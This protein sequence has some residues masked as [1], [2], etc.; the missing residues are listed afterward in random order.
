MI[1][2]YSRVSTQEQAASG[3][4]IDE[5]RL[6][7]E[8]F[9]RAM[10]WDDFQHF[11]DA[12]FSGGSKDRP[13]LLKLISEVQAGRVERVLVYKLDRLSR[14]QKDTL[15]LIEDVFLRNGA[16]FVS[17]TE[18]FDTATP[19][20]KAMVGIL[21]VFAQLEREQI[22][23]R[24][25]MGR[26]ARSKAGAFHGS[27]TIPIGY[28]YDGSLHVNDYEA[29]LVRAVFEKAAA[30]IPVRR[31]V[32]EMNGDGL[33]H[34]YGPW[35]AQTVRKML[36]RRTYLGEVCFKGTWYAG[37]HEPIIDT[38]LFEDVQRIRIASHEKAVQENARLGRATSFL[39][40]LVFCARCGAR[41]T[42]QTY[43][44]GKY[45]YRKYA[46]ASRS[47]RNPERITD[48]SCKNKTWERTD[49]EGIVFE[50]V[51][52]LALDPA[53]MGATPAGKA[54]NRM[55]LVQR[56]DDSIRRLVELYAV[57]S[58][59]LEMVKEKTQALAAQKEAL[60]NTQPPAIT[61]QDA[62]QKAAT[63]DDFLSSGSFDEVRTLLL[64]LI[65]RI[66]IDGDDITIRWKFT[67]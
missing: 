19:F 58:V 61:K 42:A 54:D 31:I 48:P 34:K 6:R 37:K 17:M 14:S 63:L 33:F 13:A 57:G 26:T 51:R 3:H 27:G 36:Q 55:A 28:D 49:L 43:H 21:A 16:D 5:Q 4:S 44:H 15:F 35:N 66:E 56:I 41:Y 25:T 47:K 12:G 39:S 32:Q 67:K 60:L 9:C 64:L 29:G 59:P 30:G 46:C 1:A 23:E 10:G 18:N 40:G 20:G 24:M 52:L 45:S 38:V 53:M 11:T 8:S 62:A 7:M 65:D 2:L 22:K 50:Q